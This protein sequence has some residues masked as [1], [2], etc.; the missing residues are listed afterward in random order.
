MKISHARL[1][2]FIGI[3]PVCSIIV[4]FAFIALGAPPFTAHAQGVSR[5]DEVGIRWSAIQAPKPVYPKA[6]IDK[7]MT[8]VVVASLLIGVDGRVETVVVLEA[9]DPSLASAVREAVKQWTF[10]PRSYAGPN[11]KSVQTKLAGNLTFYFR[12]SN[13]M[14]QV[15]NPEEMPGARW[16]KRP[17]PSNTKAQP[18]TAPTFQEVP[19]ALITTIDKKE[20]TR[21]LASVHPIILD[22]RERDAFR[23]GHLEGAVNIPFGEL[24]VRAPIELNDTR[25]IVIDC[26]QEE[27]WCQNPGAI[28]Q[29]L[30]GGGF[31]KLTV[32]R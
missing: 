17:V 26:S 5:T 29:V 32:Y 22:I 21:Q 11:G 10:P 8:G 3:R 18:A 30:H 23:R 27:S 1:S 12:I 9:P 16:P 20:L 14:G 7:G 6:A 4:V 31:S 13:G 15:L 25:L 24:Q 19:E 28:L 2:S